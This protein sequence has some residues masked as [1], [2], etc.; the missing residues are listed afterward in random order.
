V[1]DS[2]TDLFDSTARVRLMTGAGNVL[3]ATKCRPTLGFTQSSVKWVGGHSP[4]SGVGRLPG[5]QPDHSS[6]CSA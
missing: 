5:R 6:S 3:L 4:R 2:V 1:I